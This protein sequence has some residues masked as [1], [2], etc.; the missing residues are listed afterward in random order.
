M[1]PELKLETFSELLKRINKIPIGI[2]QIK[3]DDL[4][5]LSVPLTD[6]QSIIRRKNKIYIKTSLCHADIQFSKLEYAKIALQELLTNKEQ[7][8]IFSSPYNML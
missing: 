4:F 1:E 3:R 5:Y 6:V 8:I 7:R 2:Q